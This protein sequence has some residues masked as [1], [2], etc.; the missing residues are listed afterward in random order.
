MNL[1]TNCH[2]YSRTLDSEDL[3]NYRHS[4]FAKPIIEAAGWGLDVD[5]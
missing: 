1:T 2:F 4:F 3:I 5:V